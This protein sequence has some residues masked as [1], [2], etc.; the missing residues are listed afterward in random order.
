[1]PEALLA[2]A[3]LA[4]PVHAQP[5]PTPAA[6]CGIDAARVADIRGRVAA[7]PRFKR[8]GGD[9][10]RE[11]WSADSIQALWTFTTASSPAY[12]AALC[13]QLVEQEGITQIDRQLVCEASAS[14]C[15]ALEMEIA[16]REDGSGD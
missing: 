1:M 7:D 12:P 9:A 15:S 8:D 2:V 13:E 10:Q 14:A 5:A 3:L 4:A 11:V 6:R 16:G